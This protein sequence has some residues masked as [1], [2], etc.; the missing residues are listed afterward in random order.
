MS[1]INDIMD[2]GKE[3]IE[4]QVEKGFNF[5]GQDVLDKLIDKVVKE[6]NE[7]INEKGLDPVS[8]T[9]ITIP[10]NF[11]KM[12]GVCGN[13]PGL[14]LICGC[15]AKAINL[16]GDLFL[17]NGALKGLSALSRSMDTK[18]EVVDGAVK[19]TA[20]MKVTKLEAPFDTSTSV[21]VADSFSPDISALVDTVGIVFGIVIPFSS[22]VSN[23]PFLDF[24]PPL[25]ELAV[26]VDVNLG[27]LESIEELVKPYIID[28]VKRKLG[29]V[30]KAEIQELV[31][32]VTKEGIPGLK[33]LMS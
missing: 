7:T 13:I 17:K 3:F 12:A 6:C 22:G 5:I 9:D 19:I 8:I 14:S 10:F 4:D 28:P 32:R 31:Q 25:E 15:M 24:D 1:F 30:L 27:E 2:K 33:S 23:D 11:D 18:L 16:E 29:E 26:D 20:G 21:P